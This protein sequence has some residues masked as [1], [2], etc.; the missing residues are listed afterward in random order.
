MS[1]VGVKRGLVLNVINTWKTMLGVVMAR[2]YFQN[3]LQGGPQ[4]RSLKIST[5][6]G[7]MITYFKH[8]VDEPIHKFPPT[9][10]PINTYDNM[11]SVMTWSTKISEYKKY[12]EQVS[13]ESSR[14]VSRN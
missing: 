8:I 7:K 10:P 9:H 1:E 3:F 4:S 13:H 6:V 11:C 14:N 12:H 2:R 5:A